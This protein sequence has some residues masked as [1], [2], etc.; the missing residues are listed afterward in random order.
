MVQFLAEIESDMS[1]FHRVDNIYLMD[2]PLFF[3][4]ARLLTAY[5]GA[6]TGRQERQAMPTTPE[7]RAMTEEDLWANFRQQHYAE[8][9]SS[10]ETPR[11]ISVTE[12]MDIMNQAGGR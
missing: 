10:N 2:G 8:F 11:H 1:V 7:P 3:R 4:R 12:G 6:L 9:L 5:D